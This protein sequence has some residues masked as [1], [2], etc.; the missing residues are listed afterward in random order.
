MESYIDESLI[1]DQETENRSCLQYFPL[2]F[3]GALPKG[4][5][6]IE[7]P[8]RIRLQMIRLAWMAI[9]LVV[10]A[11]VLLGLVQYPEMTSGVRQ[12]IVDELFPDE[13][14]ASE[15]IK[16]GEVV[17]GAEEIVNA[18][19]VAEQLTWVTTFCRMKAATDKR[20]IGSWS[21]NLD[22][23]D[24]GKTRVVRW[25]ASN[26]RA[27]P[28][29]VGDSAKALPRT[30]VF[31]FSVSEK[32][33]RVSEERYKAMQAICSRRFL[34]DHLVIGDDPISHRIGGSLEP[35]ARF[36][37]PKQFSENFIDSILKEYSVGGDFENFA[38]DP[39]NGLDQIVGKLDDLKSKDVAKQKDLQ[40]DSSR[41]PE[42]SALLQKGDKSQKLGKAASDRAVA[43]SLGMTSE[44][45]MTLQ[46]DKTAPSSLLAR[47]ITKQRSTHRRK[48]SCFVLDAGVDGCDDGDDL[49]EGYS[50]QCFDR[51]DIGGVVREA[52]RVAD[53]DGDLLVSFDE[54]GAQ[55]LLKFIATE[56]EE[57]SM[58]AK[59][60]TYDHDKDGLLSL[61]EY[62]E[63]IRQ[64]VG[65]LAM[66][67]RGHLTTKCRNHH[68]GLIPLCDPDHITAMYTVHRVHRRPLG[69][70]DFLETMTIRLHFTSVGG[71][72]KSG[73]YRFAYYISSYSGWGNKGL[74]Q[75]VLMCSSLLLMM[76]F[77]VFDFLLTM[78]C[79]PVSLV[80]LLR[81]RIPRGTSYEDASDMMWPRIHILFDWRLCRTRYLTFSQILLEYAIAAVFAYSI[82]KSLVQA[83]TPSITTNGAHSPRCMRAMLDMDLD[84]MSSSL[85]GKPTKRGMTPFDYLLR[86][87][88]D[89]HPI[90]KLADMLTVLF[91]ETE[92]NI[93]GFVLVLMFLRVS[94]I[95]EYSKSLQ[96]LPN[97]LALARQKVAEF[98]LAL[99]VLISTFAVVMHI[100]FGNLY[101]Q[102]SSVRLAFI[103]LLMYS[104]GDI[105]RARDGMQPFVEHSGTSIT[106]YLLA[107][108]VLVVTICLN[109]FTTIVIDAYL[110]AADP[111]E[112][113]MIMNERDR[114]QLI[115]FIRIFAEDPK[116]FKYTEE[117]RRKSLI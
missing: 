66:P 34:N 77:T 103:T 114:N 16:E 96:W 108:T 32:A 50:P 1:E 55:R 26:N 79:L 68:F 105:D 9:L 47:R 107:Y 115:W 27:L 84:W 92:Q 23:I 88:D 48:K 22:D 81:S 109:V 21:C 45:N 56:E 117:R 46:S 36:N 25:D 28:D 116:Q 104:F 97:T 59:L 78:L 89:I 67:G 58:L 64:N 51:T 57:A 75:V 70:R 110:A 38:G 94:Q 113:V 91:F 12:E 80:R 90:P 52:W 101:P 73:W 85:G 31:N 44:V 65:S 63:F 69:E 54:Q 5:G 95:L 24:I 49:V 15:R 93:C 30:R 111:D 100:Q 3:Q 106:L 8:E 102:Y 87:R 18:G 11:T 10:Y 76:S 40:K 20:I 60:R 53:R 71:D 6:Q 33:A 13:G 7:G 39:A 86:C 61:S 74:F 42:E 4:T 37:D 72:E 99:C 41:S 62:I 2:V 29:D 19:D 82:Y 43:S 17:A 83:F 112:L 98:S 35:S 14:K